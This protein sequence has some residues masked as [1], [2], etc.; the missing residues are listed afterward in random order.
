MNGYKELSLSVIGQAELEYVE[1]E[2]SFFVTFNSFTLFRD[3]IHNQAHSG[4]FY[5]HVLYCLRVVFGW[6]RRKLTILSSQ[7][8]VFDST[9][10][11]SEGS[12]T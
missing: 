12:L 4:I 9:F 2:A 5:S 6:R 3:E 11:S 8:D 10:V 7:S 1:I